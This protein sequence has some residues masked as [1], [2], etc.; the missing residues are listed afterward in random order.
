MTSRLHDDHDYVSSL[1]ARRDHVDSLVGV[2]L[3]EVDL[4]TLDH[5]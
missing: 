5:D 4:F 1:R 3:V 2:I